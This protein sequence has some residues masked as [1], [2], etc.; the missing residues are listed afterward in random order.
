MSHA[1]ISIF[2]PHLGCPN[3]CSFCDQRVISSTSHAPSPDEAEEII[4][5]ASERICSP[6]DRANTEIAFFGGSFTAI[7]REYMTALLERAARYLK[8]PDRDGFR[9][10]RISTRPD[11]IDEE[12][13]ML[14]K[15]YGVTA[16]ELGAQSMK[17]SVLEANL[18]G[19]SAED[20]RRASRMISE[21][22]FELGLQMMVGLYKSSPE[23]ELF[24]M[25][26]MIKLCPK[27]VRI[28]PVAVLRGTY[29]A[30]LYDKGEYTLYPFEECVCLCARLMSGFTEAGIKIIR[31]GLH[32]EESVED[33]AAAGF[34]HPAFGELVRSE[35]V[36]EIIGNVLEKSGYAECRASNRNM[37]VL[38]GHK[39]SNKIFFADK[40]VSFLRD[41]SLPAGVISVN[42]RNFI[43][44]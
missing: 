13:L 35:W 14:L 33:R 30:E 44:Q 26:E 19:H 38:V 17:D 6:E 20:I 40:N 12:I 21:H 41:D 39:R 5:G 28:Y 9:G 32:A 24:T 1:N 10:I 36:R 42:G 43:I 34:Y 7:D 29:L 11:C 8:A 27:T 23:D 22:G 4:G 25:S 31:L 18:R 3:A 15:K 16:I 2:I 37:S